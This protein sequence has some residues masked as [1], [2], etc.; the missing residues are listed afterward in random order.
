MTYTQTYRPTGPTDSQD[1]Q[2]YKATVTLKMTKGFLISIVSILLWTAALDFAGVLDKHDLVE[3][4]QYWQD[5]RKGGFEYADV[6]RIRDQQNK[7]RSTP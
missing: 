5:V 1:L 3:A 2:T 4:F 6:E 7:P